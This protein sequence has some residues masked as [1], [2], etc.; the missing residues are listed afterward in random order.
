MVKGAVVQ[1]VQVVHT[2]NC[3][4]SCPFWAAPSQYLH[5]FVPIHTVFYQLV[6]FGY[7][8][9]GVG[10]SALIYGVGLTLK[11]IS[12][13]Y[14]CNGF[15]LFSLF[16]SWSVKERERKHCKNRD[17]EAISSDQSRP[18]QHVCVYFDL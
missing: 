9:Y 3:G 16:V 7:R 1:V 2:G 13:Q 18:S 4:P 6:L 8:D 5:C 14:C 10:D 11:V 17:Q 15:D 12:T